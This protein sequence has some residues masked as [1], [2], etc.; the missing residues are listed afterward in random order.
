[1]ADAA[2]VDCACVTLHRFPDGESLVR[3]PD[4]LPSRVVVYRSM[5]RPNDKLVELMLCAAACRDHGAVE[6]S[7]A[8]PYLCYMRQDI[9]FRSGEAVSQRV[10]GRW[11]GTLFDRV[12]TVDPHLHRVDELQQALPGVTAIALSA[13]TEVARFLGGLGER[14]LLVG[15]DQESAQWVEPIAEKTGMPWVVAT[16]RRSGD[17]EVRVDLPAGLDCRE[18]RVVLVDDVV[19]TGHTLAAAAR[20]VVAG[21]ASQ[22]SCVITHPVFCGGALELLREAGVAEVWSTD[23]IEHESNVVSLA[24]PIGGAL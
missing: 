6:L 7:L 19:S 20:G 21:G 2:G 11:L 14:L 5:D 22:V 23:S 18:T 16:K 9:A 4:R 13:S 24:T 12:I 8:A 10:V 1:M 17:R 15:P 3:V